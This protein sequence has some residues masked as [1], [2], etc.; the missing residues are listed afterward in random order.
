LVAHLVGIF[1]GSIDKRSHLKSLFS[2]VT[3]TLYISAILESYEEVS[4]VEKEAHDIGCNEV[5]F[6][7]KRAMIYLNI[8]GFFI[9]CFQG[10][11]YLISTMQGCKGLCDLCFALNRCCCPW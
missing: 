7:Q 11:L 6:S 1:I 8:F 3:G 4:T 10:V 9:N 2:M 5:L